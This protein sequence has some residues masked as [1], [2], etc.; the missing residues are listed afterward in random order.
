METPAMQYINYIS[1]IKY[2]LMLGIATF[3]YK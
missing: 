1:D 2:V 3:K